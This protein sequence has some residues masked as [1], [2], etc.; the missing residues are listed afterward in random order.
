MFI[1]IQTHVFLFPSG[2]PYYIH[3]PKLCASSLHVE[4]STWLLKVL[5][6]ETECFWIPQLARFS[7]P[8][9][10]SKGC[11]YELGL[12]RPTSRSGVG[13]EEHCLLRGRPPKGPPSG[14]FANVKLHC[15]HAEASIQITVFGESA[16][17]F[18]IGAHLSAEK[19]VPRKLF[20]AAIMQ[21]GATAGYVPLGGVASG[22]FCLR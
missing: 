9:S 17:A 15:R 20:R 18:S 1:L 4:E 14:H 7:R 11:S 16:G 3:F 2:S 19:H 6:S 21:S 22:K 12:S 13:S 10:I 5:N 8:G